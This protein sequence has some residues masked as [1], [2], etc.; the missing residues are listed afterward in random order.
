M[1]RRT[2]ERKERG[3]AKTFCVWWRKR[4]VMVRSKYIVASVMPKTAFAGYGTV[5]AQPDSTINAPA[6][7]NACLYRIRKFCSSR[8]R[9]G[10]SFIMS[11]KSVSSILSP[12][13]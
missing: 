10:L 1:V 3:T 4:R 6:F 9:A 12:K 2:T 11:G 13:I 7:S 8:V 5:K